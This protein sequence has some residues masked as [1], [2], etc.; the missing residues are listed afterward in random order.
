MRSAGCA[1]RMTWCGSRSAPHAGGECPRRGSIA[2]NHLLSA[3]ANEPPWRRI[4]QSNPGGRKLRSRITTDGLDRAPHRAFMH[5]MGLDD[6]A[7]A[8]PFIGVVTTAGET[9]PCTGTL[10]GQG[11]R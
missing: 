3:A 4:V 10:A 7:V 11:A 8:R 2:L 6:A 5:G 9:T 1:M